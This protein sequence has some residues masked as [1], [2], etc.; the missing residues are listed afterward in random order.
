MGWLPAVYR[1]SSAWRGCLLLLVL[2]LAAPAGARGA[3][4]LDQALAA[5]AL[6]AAAAVPSG[7]Q[8]TAHWTGL[9]NPMAIRFAADGRV[10]VAEKSGLIQVFD[11]VG[12]PTPTVYADLRTKVHDFWDRGLLG[13]ALDPGFTTGR[14]FVYVL[15]AY[16]HVL[17]DGA[18]PPRWGDGCPT[19]PGATA[20]GCVIS[21]RLS[22]LNASGTEQV[23]IED[24]CQ[25]YPSHSLGSLAF[26]AD[27]ALYV[28]SGDGASFNFAD[29][30]QDGS[31]LNPCGDPPGGVGAAMTP[32]TAEGGAL[33]SQDVRSTGDPTGLNGAILRV[34]PDTGAALA[35]NP[36]AGA[37]D[38]NARRII[39]TGLRNPFRTIIRPGTNEVWAGD[40]GWN[41]WEEIDRVTTPLSGIRNFGWPCYEGNGRMASYDNL[42]LNLCESLYS[43]GAGAHATP[44]FTYNH[45]AA[46]ATGDGCPTGGSSISGLA[47][48]DG[49]TF[50]SSYDG[51]LF[52]ADYS[53]RCIWVMFKG[54]NGLPDPNTR[55]AFV[56]GGPGPV[57]LQIGPGGDLFYAD[58]A[59]GTI[60]RVHATAGNQA[61]T[62]R[63]TASPSSGAPPLTVTLRRPDLER[64]ERRH[65]QL[66]LG[67][68]RRRRVRRL[69][70]SDPLVHVHDAG[71]PHRAAAGQRPQRAVG[72]DLGAR[73]CRHTAHRDDRHPRLGH[74]VEGR[75][76][77]RVLGQRPRLAGQPAAGGEARLGAEPPA[78]RERRQLSHPPGAEL[79]RRGHRVVQ[80]AGSRVPLPPRAAAQ[81]HRQ[82]RPVHH[83]DAATRPA[84]RP[85][86]GGVRSAGA[87]ALARLPDRRRSLHARAHRG[88]GE[89]DQ[90]AE[91]ADVERLELRLRVVERR[92]RREPQR[93]GE[94][95]HDPARHV[96]AQ[97]A[98]ARARGRV[99]LRGAI[100][101][102][103]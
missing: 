94:R 32:P 41:D 96:H 82:Q 43:Q 29:Y 92:R 80:R 95:R 13:L 10:F 25:Q 90:R 24:W 8:D 62:A 46:V 85:R 69:D 45:A 21:G 33:R 99:R 58:L 93:H 101:H 70:L 17:G 28:S 67:P 102:R 23:L 72:H 57:D 71:R 103:R 68:R 2:A 76:D 16:D 22:R 47:F 83:R 98:A 77:R 19:P 63:A 4:P 78:L 18:A 55:Q 3:A 51:A 11:S 1:S 36:N 75:A 74:D 48:Y 38:P 26:G 89:L 59:G 7:F 97:R 86:D 44:F 15:Y 79:P 54:A 73:A 65:P 30:G 35:D 6:V 37:S 84:H 9:T 100:G 52:F 53:R 31:P 39:A 56:T 20:D 50:P 42:N 81:G 66:R 40:V 27:G 60:H 64:S 12:D 91:P 88:L 5:D 34:N 87:A 49:G 61:P 14:P